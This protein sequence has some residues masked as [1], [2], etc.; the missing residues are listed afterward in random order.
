MKKQTLMQTFFLLLFLFLLQPVAAM[1][2]TKTVTTKKKQSLLHLYSCDFCDKSFSHSYSLTTH[3]KIH[4]GIGLYECD[5]C[6]KTFTANSLLINHQITHTKE[7]PYKC[8]ECRSSFNRKY[9]LAAHKKIHTGIGLHECDTCFKTFIA[10]SI[11]V[12]HQRTHAEKT[13]KCDE[14]PKIFSQE[15][16]LTAH[17][18]T[19]HMVQLIYI[20]STCS[21]QTTSNYLLTV[22][23]REHMNEK[24]YQCGICPK[25]FYYESWFTKHIKRDH[26]QYNS[27]LMTIIVPQEN[28]F[29]TDMSNPVKPLYELNATAK[30]PNLLEWIERL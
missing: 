28:F 18:K 26:P 17:K 23:K 16:T 12:R 14:C 20:C 11:L 9:A 30:D 1:P 6:F 21:Y 8:D 10:H 2:K 13:Y 29:L 15:S 19:K 25:S 5:T 24:P 27:L 3:E 7:K 22:H 4:T